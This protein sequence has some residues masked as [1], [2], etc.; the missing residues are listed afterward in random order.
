MW[1]WGDPTPPAWVVEP[2]N[3][4]FEINDKFYPAWSLRPWSKSFVEEIFE[5]IFSVHHNYQNFTF[6]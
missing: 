6:V 3:E 4:D 5:E 2:I 1:G